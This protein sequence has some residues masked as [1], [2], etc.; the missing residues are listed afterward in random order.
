MEREGLL[1]L[2][3]EAIEGPDEETEDE[4]ASRCGS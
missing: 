1:G 2:V 4:V 3:G